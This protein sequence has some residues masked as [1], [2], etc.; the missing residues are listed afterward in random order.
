MD[1]RLIPLAA[2]AFVLVFN[3]GVLVTGALVIAFSLGFFWGWQRGQADAMREERREHHP[4]PRAKPQTTR[5]TR[6]ASH[7]K[8]LGIQP[9]CTS[10]DINKAWRLALHKAHPDKGGSAAAILALNA[11]RN[12][13]LNEIEGRSR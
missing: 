9:P 3:F 2:V 10:A 6:I 5:P 12:C 1:S 8:I 4:N 7:W 11:A 13:A